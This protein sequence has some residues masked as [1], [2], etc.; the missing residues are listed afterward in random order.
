MELLLAKSAKVDYHDPYIPHLTPT[1][2]YDFRMSSVD[3]S[4]ETLAGYDLVILTTD[5]DVFDYDLI[6]QNAKYII[7]TRG[8][9]RHNKLVLRA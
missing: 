9:Y 2:D 6:L 1:R 8:R 5:H 3:I 7:D 4:A